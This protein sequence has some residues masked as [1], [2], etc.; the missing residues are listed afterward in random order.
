M[1]LNDIQIKTFVEKHKMIEPFQDFKT[2]EGLS[3]GLEPAG[4]TL[5]LGNTFK[6]LNMRSQTI[7]PCIGQ[8]HLYQTSL[9]ED[10]FVLSP[11]SRV[12]CQ[13][14]E[15]LNLPNFI[16]ADLWPKSSYLRAGIVPHFALVEPGWR[17]HLTIE[18]FNTNPFAAKLYVGQG[19]VQIRFHMI[20]SA[21]ETYDGHYQDLTTPQ[22]S[23]VQ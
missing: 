6:T 16:S 21:E 18:V 14:M 13:V 10:Y 8:E 1:L 15:K 20:A 22:A 19:I 9:R 12:L 11:Q 5:R 7:D 2:K 23:L 17:G 3:Y 4:Y